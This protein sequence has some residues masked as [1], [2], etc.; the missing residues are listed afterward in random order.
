MISIVFGTCIIYTRSKNSAVLLI[1]MLYTL[2]YIEF[3]YRSKGTLLI[4]DVL[5]YCSIVY[6][7]TY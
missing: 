5:S 7:N 3:K 4:C 1:F 2:Y 6:I